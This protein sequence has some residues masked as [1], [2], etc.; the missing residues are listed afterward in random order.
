MLHSLKHPK[1]NN[2]RR[3]MRRRSSFTVFLP[4]LTA[5][6]ALTACGGGG[7]GDGDDTPLLPTPTYGIGGEVLGLAQWPII[8]A[9]EQWLQ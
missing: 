1:L 9:A 6:L 2:K 8:G 3:H 5:A 4:L 7:S